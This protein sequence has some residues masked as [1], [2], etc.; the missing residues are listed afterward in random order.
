MNTPEKFRWGI[1]ATGGIAKIQTADLQLDKSRV[2]AVGSRSLNSAENFARNFN[3]PHYYGTYAEL[4]GSSE[5]D[6]IYVASPHA[7]H[8]EHALRAIAGGKHVLVE[9]AFTLNAEEAEKVFEAARKAGVFVME[10]M[11]TRFLPSM[12]RLMEII[13]GGGI[14]T[15]R[16]LI[17][18]HN[19]YIP[20]SKAPRVHDPDL[21]GGALLDL[22]VYLLSFAS[23]LFG[24]PESMEISGRLNDMGADEIAAMICDYAHGAQAVLHCA[25]M[26]P[27]SNT[28]VVAGD[29]GRI[30]IDRIWYNQTSF[31]HY[32][33]EGDVCEKY[34]EKVP[35]RGMQ[36]QTR[37]VEHCISRGIN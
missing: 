28:A 4:C 21:G 2:T 30:E 6:I 29:E 12:Q 37:E 24:T 22:G 7:F 5:V 25:S 15:P 23:R 20:W 14:G 19:Q 11:W 33:R 1:L 3:I 9:K 10:A 27:G 36:Y 35:G 8:C 16:V 13:D 18:D 32:N 17:A 31:T 34:N 26:I